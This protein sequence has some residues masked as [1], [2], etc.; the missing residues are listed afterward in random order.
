[1]VVC[2]EVFVWREK[3]PDTYARIQSPARLETVMCVFVCVVLV[4]LLCLS[5]GTNVEREKTWL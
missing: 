3:K 5:A 1:M 4:S 2:Q